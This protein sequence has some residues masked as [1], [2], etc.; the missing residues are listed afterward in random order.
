MAMAGDGYR[1]SQPATGELVV[2]EP[3]PLRV[4]I[5]ALV[6]RRGA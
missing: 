3:F 4:D 5:D 6:A 1:E 2:V